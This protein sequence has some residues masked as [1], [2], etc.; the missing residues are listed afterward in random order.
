MPPAI[1]LPEAAD[2]LATAHANY[3][4]LSAGLGDRF[5][6]AVR[7]SVSLIETNPALYGEVAPGIRACLTRQFPFEDVGTEANVRVGR[8]PVLARSVWRSVTVS[9]IL[10]TVRPRFGVGGTGNRT[11]EGDL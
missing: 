6:E 2:D 5:L 9:W 10:G 1:F 8:P 4:A 3:E 11:G 7:R